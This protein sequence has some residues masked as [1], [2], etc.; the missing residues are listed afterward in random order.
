MAHPSQKPPSMTSRRKAR[1]FTLVELSIVVVIISILAVLAVVGYRKLIVSSHISEATHMISAIRLA[2]EQYHSEAQT[3][4]STAG[5]LGPGNLYPNASPLIPPSKTSWGAGLAGGCAPPVPSLGCWAALPLHVDSALMF[6]Y[7]TF[8]GPAGSVAWPKSNGLLI[9]M[10]VATVT[11]WYLVEAVGDFDG[12]GTDVT[13]F[14]TSFT[15]DIFIDKEG[16]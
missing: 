15:N 3:Y 10:P 6:N 13:V 4:V 14:G 16:E 11:D 8:S 7:V 5:A 9:G 2:Q 12:N 1:G